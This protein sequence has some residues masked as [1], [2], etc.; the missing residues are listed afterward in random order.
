MKKTVWTFGLIAGAILSVMMLITLP[1]H[2]EIGFDRAEIIGY[3]S[4][5]AAFLLIFFGVRSYRDNVRNGRVSFG[6]ALSVA[7][8]IALVAS[9]CYAATW[10]VVY[11]GVIGTK[12]DFLA[13][14]QEHQITKAR[15]G[16]ATQA[17]IDKQVADN[18]RMLELY[19][20]PVINFG[21]T[22][23]E[24]LPVGLVLSLVS[25]GVLSRRR[26]SGMGLAEAAS[27]GA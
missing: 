6:R 19:N 11:F 10:Q 8:L 27:Q 1:F 15:E 9:G 2:D 14:Y 26:K 20:N 23:L 13:K 5:V 17:Q 3:T 12:A 22:I 18:R 7:V 25:A 21:M 24:P 16:G 4:M